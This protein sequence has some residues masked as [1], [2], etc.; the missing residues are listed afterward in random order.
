[1]KKLLLILTGL[2]LTLS[3]LTQVTYIYDEA[4]NRIKREIKLNKTAELAADSTLISEAVINSETKAVEFTNPAL[5]E[6]FGEVVVKLYPNPTRGAVYIQ[7]NQMPAE[8][9]PPVEVWSPNGAL[10]EK[11][12]ITGLTT[13]INLWGRPGGIYFVKTVLNGTPVTWKIIKK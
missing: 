13:R 1:M 12:K 5:E 4:G 9:Q 11:A 3:G 2:V 6:A 7:L 10:I 8:G